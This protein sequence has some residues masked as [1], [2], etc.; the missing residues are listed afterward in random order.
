VDGAYAF[1]D[2]LYPRLQ[3]HSPAETE[4]LWLDRP[5]KPPFSLLSAPAAAPMRRDPRFLG[6][7]QRIGL[8]GYWRSGR[9]PDFCRSAS[10]EPVCAEIR[11]R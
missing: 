8:L 6:L 3:G 5:G 10:P 4:A 2:R 7:A 1:A 11:R 9:L